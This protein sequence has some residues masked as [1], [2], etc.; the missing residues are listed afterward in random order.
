[1]IKKDIRLG[2]DFASSLLWN[3]K[4]NVYEYKRHGKTLN[5]DE[6]SEYA[7]YLIN[8]YDLIY[9]EDPLNEEDFENVMII[10]KGNPL[11][12]VTGD[13]LLVT[14]TNRAGQN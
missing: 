6:Q 11:C 14:N 9:A 8:K 5:P 3:P 2:I 13:D 7:N 1:M 4:N 12:L 10:T